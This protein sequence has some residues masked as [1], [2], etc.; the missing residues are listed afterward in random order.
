AILSALAETLLA[1]RHL[2]RAKETAQRVLDLEEDPKARERTWRLRAVR[3]LA[4]VDAATGDLPAAAR[5]LDEAIDEAT[6][7]KSPSLCGML[8]EARAGVAVAAGDAELVALHRRAAESWYRSTKNPALVA[9][10]G[11]LPEPAA[12]LA[13]EAS[14]AETMVEKTV[15][16]SPSARD[17]EEAA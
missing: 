1:Q 9:R 6:A 4:M 15:A 10:I 8:H 11:R 14:E 2:A 17:M 16:A 5:R 12:V 3:I 7:L 13:H